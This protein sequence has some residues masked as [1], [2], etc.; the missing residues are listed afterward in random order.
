MMM[1]ESIETI[2]SQSSELFYQSTSLKDIENYIQTQLSCH[3]S[4]ILSNKNPEIAQMIHGMFQ[5]FSNTIELKPGEIQQLKQVLN[6]TLDKDYHSGIIRQHEHTSPYHLSAYFSQICDALS[7]TLKATVKIP[8]GDLESIRRACDGF[9]NREDYLQSKTIESITILVNEILEVISDKIQ[10][11]TEKALK[12]ILNHQ[13]EMI[14]KRIEKQLQIYLHSS[15]ADTKIN[16]VR[17][18]CGIHIQEIKQIHLDILDLQFQLDSQDLGQIHLQQRIDQKNHFEVF[19]GTLGE[20]IFAVKCISLQDFHLQEVLYMREIKHKNVMKYYGVK[21]AEMNH[22]Y[23]IIMPRYDS[24]LDQYINNH[25]TS[26]NPMIIHDM[27]IQIVKGLNYIHTQLEFIHGNLRKDNILVRE[28]KKRFVI[29]QLGGIDRHLDYYSAPEIYSTDRSNVLTE[30]CD[31]YS[32]GVTIQ[33]I[34]R[35]AHQ[36]ESKDRLI[37]IWLQIVEKCRLQEAIVRPSCRRIL[38]NVSSI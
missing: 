24:N 3:F 16:H 18:Y 38:E 11:K 12:N 25:R 5:E 14:Q 33:E 30:K 29:G 34:I 35:S 17:R 2:A 1:N 23:S 36:L 20:N 32:L 9:S 15:L 28:E 4:D 19:Q 13:L 10:L 8:V 31:I 26:L 27:I 21:K 7:E 37:G 6:E 22:Y